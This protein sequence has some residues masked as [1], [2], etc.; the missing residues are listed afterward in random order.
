MVLHPVVFVSLTAIWLITRRIT[1][2]ASLGS[3]VIAVG[4]PIGVA[5]AGSPAWETAST[6]G[7]AALVVLRHAGNIK[8]LVHGSEP[9]ATWF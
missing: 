2:K 8:R 6:I 9:S 1:G 5:L 4:L 7:L 3:I